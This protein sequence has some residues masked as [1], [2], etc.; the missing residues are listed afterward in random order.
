MNTINLEKKIFSQENIYAAIYALHSYIQEPNLLSEKDYE[1]YCNL[2]DKYNREIIQKTI[3]ECS[4]LLSSVYR[5]NELFSAKVHFKL[6]GIKNGVFTFRPIHTCDLKTYICLVAMLQPIMF[7]DNRTRQYSNVSQMI[8]GNFYGNRPSTQI[9]Y[10]YQKWQ[11]NYKEYS[12]LIIEKSRE[13]SQNGRF[14]YEVSLDLKDFFPSVSPSLLIHIIKNKCK[15]IYNDCDFLEKTLIKLLYFKLSPENINGWESIYYLNIKLPLAKN[16]KLTTRGIPQGLPQAPFFGN[17]FMERIA[18]TLKQQFDGDALFYVDDSIIFTNTKETEYN[19]FIKSHNYGKLLNASGIPRSCDYRKQNI[20]SVP[21]ML[22]KKYRSFQ[23][24]LSYEIHFHD[25]EKS[26]HRSLSESS[27]TN[28]ALAFLR[29]E[30]S[31]AGALYSV[32]DEYEDSSSLEKVNTII[33]MIE[34]S[35]KKLKEAPGVGDKPTNNKLKLLRRHLRFFKFRERVLLLRKTGRIEQSAVD[36]FIDRFLKPSLSSDEEKEKYMMHFDE[37]IFHAEYRLILNS[38]PG[39]EESR[40][41]FLHKLQEFEESI[42]PKGA[43]PESLYFKHDANG[44]HLHRYSRDPSYDSLK[45]ILHEHLGA[46]R[47]APQPIKER[48]LLSFIDDIENK[49]D[50]ATIRSILIPEYAEFVAASSTQY[51]RRIF[52]AACSYLFN[53]EVNDGFMI[54]K[55]SSQPT[56]YDEFRALAYLRNRNCDISI[57]KNFI[58]SLFSEKDKIVD[59]QPIDMSLVNILGVLVRYVRDATHIDNIIQTHRKVSSLWKNGSKFLN[60]Y[61]LHN[62]DHAICLIRQC[63]HLCNTIDYLQLKQKDFYLLFLACYLHDISMVLHPNLND[64]C[65]KTP[66]TVEIISQLNLHLKKHHSTTKLAISHHAALETFRK[67]FEYFEQK[68][69]DNHAKDSAA[70]IQSRDGTSFN[71]IENADLHIIADVALAHGAEAESVYLEKSKAH[72][73]LFSLKYMKI[74]IRLADLMDMCSERISFSRMQDMLVAMSPVSRFHWISHLFTQSARVE[75][76][77]TLQNND[78]H[79]HGKQAIHELIQVNIYLKG[80]S[81]LHLPNNGICNACHLCTE[82]TSTSQMEELSNAYNCMKIC[83]SVQDSG[84]PDCPLTCLWFMKKNKWL[85]NELSHLK[86]YLNNVNSRIFETDFEINY[87]YKNDTAIPSEMLQYI[88][89]QLL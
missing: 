59:T 55:D 64:F 81:L 45:L 28:R 25:N 31:L 67:V 5:T 77:Y 27:N 68:V 39:T 13:Y 44:C 76:R 46:S 47:L 79:L 84:K 63:V 21:L 73:S 89:E 41:Y 40:L 57:A 26:Y 36:S 78:T 65:I 18:E 8:P 24:K 38:L 15:S 1:L 58:Q 72:D 87:F 30:V 48:T 51:L 62:E 50:A 61:T 35:L 9:D 52:N 37:D 14:A 42:A 22:K 2:K 20:P 12:D 60:D 19:E 33:Q 10:L 43:E 6:K 49:S 3:N 7:C 56:Y 88:K 75:T 53:V 11:K 85:F 54:C 4:K 29:R 83:S 17:I 70:Y 86:E 82:K 74:L 71:Y 69:R 66:E 34:G 16:A 23:N 32:T 80:A